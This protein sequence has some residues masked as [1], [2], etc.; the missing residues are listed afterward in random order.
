M[1]KSH[2]GV[3]EGTAEEEDVLPEPLYE[4]LTAPQFVE[5]LSERS[6]E[7]LRDM[8]AA[9]EQM[10]AAI[11]FARR[12]LHG[13]LDIVH[14]DLRRRSEGGLSSRLADL[15]EQ[16]PKIL[17]ETQPTGVA[18]S[19]RV[20]LA[21]EPSGAQDELMALVDG[22]VGPD[23]LTHLAQLDED[24]VESTV[25]A[26]SDLEHELSTA[27]RQLHRQ[28]DLLQG[29]LSSRYGRGELSVETLLA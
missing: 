3:A 29:E 22:V 1:L 19:Q 4:P 27:R 24:E 9:C 10:E 26:L 6:A 7:E 5:H 11:S 13:R 28:I 2:L 8:R 16:L 15:V 17:A 21:A 20:L 12:A 18:S 23:A 14:A 25:T